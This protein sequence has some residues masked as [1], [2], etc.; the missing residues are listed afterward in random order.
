[1]RG[2]FGLW[3]Q[4][5]A[6]TFLQ[7]NIHRFDG[8]PTSVTLMGESSGASSVHWHMLSPQSRGLFHRASLLI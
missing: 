1:M 8:D 7:E 6:L 3:D 4:N 5:L 2:N